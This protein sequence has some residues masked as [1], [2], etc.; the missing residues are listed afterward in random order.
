MT[1][2]NN[3]VSAL[4]ERLES[5]DRRAAAR[6]ISM[7]EDNDTGARDIIKAIYPKTGKAHIVGI[8]GP[9][10]AG[11]STLADKLT[12]AVRASGRSV[13]VVAVDPTSPFTGG[14]LLGDRVRMQDHFTDPEVFIRS[15]A[16][17]GW[18]GGLAKATKDVVKVMDAMGKDVI[19]VETVGAGQSEVSIIQA[20]HT[21]IVVE[22]PGLGDDIQAIKA[23]IMEIGD[24]FVVNKSDRADSARTVSEREMMLDLNQS[25]AA[26][27][28][29]VLQTVAR[30]NKGIEELLVKIDE[31][32][33]HLRDSGQLD[34]YF[35]KQVRAEFEDLLR[36]ELAKYMLEEYTAKNV[37][38]KVLEKLERRELDPYSAVQQLMEPLCKK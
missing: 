31:H 17:R 37:L 5:G 12:R 7:L 24:I 3:E 36:E 2:Q 20:A 15:M 6:I 21:S 16:T 23:G 26:W 33:V 29:P 13:G 9:P 34:D 8:T 11:K 4:A 10:G 27:R 38:E 25:K 14:A 30:D 32:M 18:L 35:K 28:P 22:M 1:E 19:F